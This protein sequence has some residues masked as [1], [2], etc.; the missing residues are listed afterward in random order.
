VGAPNDAVFGQ[1][2]V[3]FQQWRCSKFQSVPKLP[4]TEGFP[5]PN[6]LF[7]E[8]NFWTGRTFSHRLKFMSMPHWHESHDVTGN[9]FGTARIKQNPDYATEFCSQIRIQKLKSSRLQ[10]FAPQPG[11]LPLDP[12]GG[13]VPRPTL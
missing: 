3:N 8:E 11:A 7:L 6:F 2:A 9:K 13:S 4:P 10:G 12:A 1:T 5:A